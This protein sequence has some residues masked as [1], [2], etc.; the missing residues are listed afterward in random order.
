MA[1][2][3]RIGLGLAALGR[4]DYINIRSHTDIDKSVDAFKTN[5]LKIL[6]EAHKLGL[7]DFDVAP[8]YGLGEQFLLEWN[9]TRDHKDI[10]LST[11]FGYTYVANWEIGFKGK[12]EIKEHSLAKLNEQWEVSRAFLPRLNIYQ[13]HSATLDSGVLTNTAVL[14]RLHELKEKH[15]VKIGIT[16][17]GTA[18][19]KIIQEAQKIA[20]DGVGLFDSYQVTFNI[21]EQST[22]T[23][24]KELIAKEK[25]VIIKEALANGRVLSNTNFK[26]YEVAYDYL[27]ALSKK[28]DVGIDAIAIR[29]IMDDLEP[30]IV[31]S[32]ASHIDHLKQ[33]LK[34]LDF[35]LN[36][37]EIVQLKSFAISAQDY[38]N[39]RSTLKWY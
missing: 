11:K 17:S 18:Q 33:N 24:L 14:S 35:G 30:T 32:G 10:R 2:K 23:I 9:K 15:N 36:G 27:E 1:Q 16:S 21:F 5:T 13:I 25:T 37:D 7:R 34:A 39:E 26:N 8:S 28:Y 6:D 38:W 31:L 12:H 3:T 4:P 22:S 20:F 19:E 29:F